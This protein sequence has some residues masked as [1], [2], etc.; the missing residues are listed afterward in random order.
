MMSYISELDTKRFGFPIAKLFHANKEKINAMLK[1]IDPTVVKMII[2]RVGS[3]DLDAVHIAEENGFKLM[4]TLVRYRLDLKD[5]KDFPE[6]DPRSQVRP[7]K[8]DDIPTL[9]E[10][11]REGFTS[12]YGHYHTDPKLPS[13]KCTEIY[14]DWIRRSIDTPGVANQVFVGVV[15]GQVVGFSTAVITNEKVGEFALAAVSEKT[16]GAGV[17]SNFVRNLIKYFTQN[18]CVAFEVDTQINNIFVQRAWANMGLRMFKSE[19]TLHKW[20]G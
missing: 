11:A 13:D 9:M 15:D 14:I 2:L 20:L 18:G 4:D 17:Y 8:T 12:Y 1:D 6:L 3:N 10:I 19:Y 7:V 16:R 5:M